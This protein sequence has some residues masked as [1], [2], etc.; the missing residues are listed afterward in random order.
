MT[1]TLVR[2]RLGETV[3]D[4][5]L[6]IPGHERRLN[7]LER[8]WLPGM[9]GGMPFGSCVPDGTYNLT[10]HTRPNGDDVLALRNPSMGVYYR[11]GEVPNEG[12]RYLVLIHKANWVHQIAGCIAP[13]LTRIIDQD[14]RPMVTN[15]GKAMR[16]IMEAGGGVGGFLEI[17][18]RP[19]AI[20][21]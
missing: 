14:G 12:G 8:P 1:W 2:Y 15:S 3:T 19:G 4:G 18:T 10:G 6:I 21:N 11:Q 17:V 16:I 20:N 9:R 5:Q 13:G 7:T